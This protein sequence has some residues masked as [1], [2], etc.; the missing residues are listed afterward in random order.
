MAS[1]I[2]AQERVF[3]VREGLTREQDTLPKRVFNLQLPGIW[4]EDKLDPVKFEKMLDEYYEAMEWSVKT[5]IPTPKTLHSL[6][7]S[8]VAADLKRLGKLPS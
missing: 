3:A 5:G 6:K 7:L 8:D 2:A 4:P 1:R